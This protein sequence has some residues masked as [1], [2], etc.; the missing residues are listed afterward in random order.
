MKEKDRKEKDREIFL[1]F[2][3]FQ[4]LKSGP[5]LHPWAG[6]GCGQKD[7]FACLQ[8]IPVSRNGTRVPELGPAWT[9]RTRREAIS[10]PQP[11]PICPPL[12]RNARS[13]AESFDGFLVRDIAVA[14]L[15][16]RHSLLK[17]KLSSLGVLVPIGGDG[18]Y[19]FTHSSSLSCG[20]TSMT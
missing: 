2:F 9:K 10:S 16:P 5:V 6:G 4:F 12:L 3:S 17:T 20:G 19:F 11:D 1:N 15:P 8:Y 18:E 14:D 7:C 13:S